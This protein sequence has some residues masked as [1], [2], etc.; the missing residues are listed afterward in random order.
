MAATARAGSTPAPIAEV[1]TA[2]R[3]YTIDIRGLSLWTA[4]TRGDVARRF[5]A[6]HA[7]GGVA[8]LGGV[9]IEQVH[10][11]FRTEAQR[12]STMSMGPVLD[13]MRSFLRFL[14]AVGVHDRDLSG[15]L[16]AITTQRHPRLPRHVSPQVVRALLGSCDRNSLTGRRDYAVLLLLSR[17]ALR[18]NEVARLELGDLHW[19]AAELTVHSKTGR[20]DRL[21]LPTDVG[22]ALADYLEHR[23]AAPDRSVFRAVLS[24][25]G[26]MTR[27]AVVFVP[28]TA[29]AR[30]GLPVVG[31]HQLRHTTATGLL[32]AGASLGEVGQVLR[33]DRDQTTALY[34]A[35]DARSLEPLARPWPL[36][37]TS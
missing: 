33:H 1:V 6:G 3:E 17:L 16:P 11:F 25:F 5:V 20:L 27:N 35:V 18:A 23:P 9:S 15:C 24:P 29:S 30:A 21:P 10:E 36:A 28:R 12:L 26:P 34:A 22:T 7:P 4:Q 31:A 14:F 19:R 8:D 13:S 2:F 37:M 32:R